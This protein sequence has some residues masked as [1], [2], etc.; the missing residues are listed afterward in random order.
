M[1]VGKAEERRY[2]TGFADFNS[3]SDWNTY[4][5]LLFCRGHWWQTVHRRIQI[6]RPFRGQKML[7][8][9]HIPALLKDEV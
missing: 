7:F 3:Q 2:K 8:T 9:V 4:F 6:N 5:F 1:R